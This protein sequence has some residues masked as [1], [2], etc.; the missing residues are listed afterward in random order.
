MAGGGIELLVGNFHT[1]KVLF[2]ALA[3]VAVVSVTIVDVIPIYRA[4]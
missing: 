4:H 3:L 2:V 1:M